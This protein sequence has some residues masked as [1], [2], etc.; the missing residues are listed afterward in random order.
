[1]LTDVPIGRRIQ[2]VKMEMIQW[3]WNLQPERVK[4]EHVVEEF[5]VDLVKG[6]KVISKSKPWTTLEEI[7]MAGNGITYELQVIKLFYPMPGLGSSDSEGSMP[8][9]ISSSDSEG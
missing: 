7:G 1:M 5:D 4:E 8:G 3:M 9:L 6:N 2:D